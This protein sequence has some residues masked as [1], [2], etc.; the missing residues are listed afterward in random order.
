MVSLD[1]IYAS[2][3]SFKDWVYDQFD[4]L[5]SRFDYLL[6]GLWDA[7][8]DVKDE[9]YSRVD[10][11][12]GDVWGDTLYLYDQMIS[13][14]DYLL[15]DMWSEVENIKQAVAVLDRLDEVIDSRIDQYRDKIQ[16]WIEDKLIDI[17]WNVGQKEV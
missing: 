9:I 6:M 16:G 3:R 14:I 5:D 4:Y 12:L 10:A 7:I 8:D 2:L 15:A 1:F 13:R 17:V 11:V